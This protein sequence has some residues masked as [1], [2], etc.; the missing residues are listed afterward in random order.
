MGNAPSTTAAPAA[1]ADAAIPVSV[2]V[3]V[4]NEER[5]LAVCLPRLAGFAE[6]IVVDSGSTD[7]T[8]EIAARHGAT[9]V[10]FRWDGRFPKKRN[11]CLRNLTFRAPWVLFLDADE[12]VDEAFKEELRATL[13]STACAG[14]AVRFDNWFAG[15]R[16]RFGDPMRK[17]ILFRAGAGEYERIDEE[18]WSGLDMEVHEHPVLAGPVG[19]L[20]TRV[21]H[22]DLKPLSAYIERHNGYSSWEARRFLRM[23]ESPA[24][25]LTRRQ[26]IKYALLDSYALGPLYFLGAYVLKGGFLDGRAGLLFALMKMF[27]FLQVKGKIDEFRR[28]AARGR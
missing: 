7:R 21:E 14:F 10:D 18:N 6:V 15:R 28:E 22:R 20:R 26:R 12:Y 2:V 13:G 24:V 16:L 25:R 8:R 19:C 1:P 5:N 11:W 27:Y 9:V 23:C 17:I 3:P 4:R